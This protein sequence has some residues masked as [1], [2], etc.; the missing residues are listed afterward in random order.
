[1]SAWNQAIA[2]WVAAARSV[3]AEAGRL[4]ADGDPAGRRPPDVRP[5]LSRLDD[6]D[7]AEVLV[8]MNQ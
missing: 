4:S 3:E 1:V 5:Q 7:R 6:T 2:Q 8:F